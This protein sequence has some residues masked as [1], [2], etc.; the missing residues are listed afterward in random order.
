MKLIEPTKEYS[1]SIRAYRA[2][3]LS[4]GSSMDGTGGL[5][6]FEDPLDW[7][8]FCELGKHFE[9]CPGGL[10]PATQ[11]IFVR[12][13]DDKVVGML[14]IRHSLDNDT[15]RDYGGHIGYSVLPSERRKGYAKAMLRAALPECRR[16]GLDRVLITCYAGNEGSR[17]TILANGG[18][19]E[20]T[21]RW[22]EK[23]ETLE[24]YWIDVPKLPEMGPSL[25]FVSLAERPQLERAAAEWFNSKWHVPTEAYLECMDEV[26]SGASPYGWYLCL[27]GERI[28]GGLG[29]IEN[30]F[31]ERKDLA[32]NVCAVYTEEDHRRMGIA[33]R[34]LDMAVEDMRAKGIS[35]VYLLTDH[36]GF[37]ER[38]GWEFYC[39]SLGDG[40]EE[41]ARLYVHY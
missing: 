41:P 25:T 27:D 9:K 22:E 30:D 19:Y 10:V 28:V 4:C 1:E 7:I 21:V 17:R 36:T 24:R 32:P 12:E 3:F 6:R 34:L 11:Y 5:R 40:E 14:Q 16:L 39:Y 31:H 15:L 13:T 37:Y 2:E 23:D 33:G 26:L 29:V 35:P 8:G 38:Y 20:S 18:K